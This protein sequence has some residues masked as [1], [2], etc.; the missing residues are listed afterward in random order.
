MWIGLSEAYVENN[1]YWNARNVLVKALDVVKDIDANSTI[2]L[3][4]IMLDINYRMFSSI[5]SSVDKLAELAINNHEVKDNVARTL[6]HLAAYLMQRGREEDARK[7]IEKATEILP[8]DK[9]ILQTK[10]EIVNYTTN[11][12]EFHKLETDKK[13]K[14]EIAALIAL[15]V[16]TSS[17]LGPTNKEE[18]E[19]MTHFEEY[20][21]LDNSINKLQ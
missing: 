21:I 1:Q 15:E 5:H 19:A 17:E 3:E 14:Q 13:V 6:S 2:Y 11:I 9:E 10:K 12:K 7:T 20:T 8:E 4:L 16:L 18:K